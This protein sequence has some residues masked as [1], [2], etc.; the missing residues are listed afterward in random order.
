MTLQPRHTLWIAVALAAL[1]VTTG[2][3]AGQTRT[4]A[5]PQGFLQIPGIPGTSSAPPYKGWIEVTSLAHPAATKGTVSP[6]DFHFT[7]KL[8]KAYPVFLE[9][10][11]RGTRF[12]TIRVAVRDKGDDPHTYLQITLENARISKY[13]VEGQV[14]YITMTCERIERSREPAPVAGP[15]R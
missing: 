4:G 6:Y 11:K 12:Q 9:A 15:A 8:D 2:A 3:V 14:E 5:A 10:F 13:R 1:V 7:K